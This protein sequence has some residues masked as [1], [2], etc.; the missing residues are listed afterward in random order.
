MCGTGERNEQSSS[1]WH[2]L[3]RARLGDQFRPRGLRSRLVDED[4]E[5]PGRA[6]RYIE[7]RLPDLAA[8]DLSNE[9]TPRRVRGR[10]RSF[11]TLES[12]LDGAAHVQMR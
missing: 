9:A 4:R 5:A 11:P 1:C 10:T 12:A 2:R 3:R 6:L 7:Q 8:T